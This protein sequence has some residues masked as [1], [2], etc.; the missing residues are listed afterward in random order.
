MANMYDAYKSFLPYAIVSVYLPEQ[1]VKVTTS[2][3]L[4]S[5]NIANKI[6]FAFAVKKKN[7]IYLSYYFNIY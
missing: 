3:A 5:Q 2:Q 1:K 6:V 7:C 4:D